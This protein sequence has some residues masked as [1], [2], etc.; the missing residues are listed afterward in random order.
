M[1]QPDP[2]REALENSEWLQS[3]E[4][5]HRTGGPHRLKSLL[6]KLLAAANNYG[7]QIRP[8]ASTPYINTI[9]AEDTHPCQNK[10]QPLLPNLRSKRTRQ[11]AS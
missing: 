4:D 3:L 8:P 2:K 9:S 1:P 11:R 5:I 7:I 6:Q 10:K